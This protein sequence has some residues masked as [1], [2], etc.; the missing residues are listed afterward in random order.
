MEYRK[1][2]AD[3]VG[4]E[5][6]DNEDDPTPFYKEKWQEENSQKELQKDDKNR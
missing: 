5:E 6:K 3:V 2:G 1:K 4:E